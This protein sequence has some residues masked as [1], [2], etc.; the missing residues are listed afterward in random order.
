MQGFRCF[1]S[2]LASAVLSKYSLQFG[3]ERRDVIP[4][5]KKELIWHS[6]ASGVFILVK[7]VNRDGCLGWRKKWLAQGNEIC[8]DKEVICGRICA[9]TGL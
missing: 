3:S 8:M 7:L 9:D 5:P 2:L 6:L 1:P 4:P